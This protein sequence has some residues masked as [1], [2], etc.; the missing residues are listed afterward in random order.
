MV[1]VEGST[2]LVVSTLDELEAIIAEGT[3]RRHVSGTQMNTESSR[4]HLILS[5]IIESTN[6]Q[7]QVLVKGKVRFSAKWNKLNFCITVLESSIALPGF[8]GTPIHLISKV[9]LSSAPTLTVRTYY[10]ISF[11]AAKF[12][13][14]GWI[15]ESEEVWFKWGAIEGSSKYQQVF[16]R[17][18]RRY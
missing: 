13:G 7:T 1:V 17:I 14:F 15:R 12:C 9:P 4:S 6:L 5:I 16:I 3:K 10:T 18:G 11:C 2:L 8:K